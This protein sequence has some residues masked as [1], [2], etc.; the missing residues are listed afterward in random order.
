MHLLRSTR[1]AARAADC[2]RLLLLRLL[3]RLHH[4][5]RPAMEAV[6]ATQQAEVERMTAGAS[7]ELRGLGAAPRLNGRQGTIH[8]WDSEKGRYA[9]QLTAVPAKWKN[10]G[11]PG[12]G[13]HKAC[14][15]NAKPENLWPVPLIAATGNVLLGNLFAMFD[16]DEDGF[17]CLDELV[18][19]VHQCHGVL[20]SPDDFA[21]ICLKQGSHPHWGLRTEQF[22]AMEKE[23]EP[24]IAAAAAE[25]RE[26]GG[27]G[28][29]GAVRAWLDAAQGKTPA[30]T[31]APGPDG[32]SRSTTT[33]L[34]D[35]PEAWAEWLV[36]LD[37]E[38]SDEEKFE[39]SC[40]DDYDGTDE[41]VCAAMRGNRRCIRRRL[42]EGADVN[43]RGHGPGGETALHMACLYGHAEAVRLLL[44]HGAD[45][46]YQAGGAYMHYTTAELAKQGAWGKPGEWGDKKDQREKI[47]ATL[48]A[49]TAALLASST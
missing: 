42:A 44:Q 27:E 26:Q 31:R 4:S 43:V 3:L 33:T 35:V 34:S 32:L 36:S 49:Q 11:G 10:F 40:T 28:E 37:G 21:A 46:R 19:C 7:V 23:L 16:Q 20:I 17:L 2:H 12:K 30:P 13:R 38:F 14:A 24:L 22:Q 45:Q 25:R 29:P 5:S 15:V 47:V 8:S 9:V 6:P 1:V 39:E 41:I 18:S 48:E